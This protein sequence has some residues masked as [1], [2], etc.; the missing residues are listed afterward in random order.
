MARFIF[1]CP[2]MLASFVVLVALGF[3]GPITQAQEVSEA[4]SPVT[5]KPSLQVQIG[6]ATPRTGEQMAAAAARETRLGPMTRRVKRFRPTIGEQEYRQLKA[7]AAESY[8][9]GEERAT[10][11]AMLTPQATPVLKGV[12]FAG[13]DRNGAAADIGGGPVTSEVADMHGAAGRSFLVSGENHSH[14]V[15]VSNSHVN[16]YDVNTD[17]GARTQVK[18]LSLNSFFGYLKP[19][20]DNPQFCFSPRVIYDRVWDRWIISAAADPESPTMMRFFFAVSRTSDPTGPFFVYNLNVTF[21]VADR[22]WDFPQ[23]GMD[24]DAIIFTAN[25]FVD[26]T[27]E[28]IDGRMITL[29]KALFYNG[30]S[31]TVPLFSGLVASVAPPL[32]LDRNRNT[33]LVAALPEDNRVTLYNLNHSSRSAPTLTVSA[34]GVPLYTVPPPA[35]QPGTTNKLDTLDSRFLSYSTQAGSRLFQVHT[36]SALVNNVAV[37]TPKFYEF[38]TATRTIVQQGLFFKSATSHDFNATIAANP[39]RD[40]WVTWSATDPPS[41][42]QAQVRFSGRRS[43]DPTGVIPAGSSLAGSAAFYNPSAATVERWGD[44][45]AVALDPSNSLRAW[46]VNERIISNTIWG[47][48]IGRIGF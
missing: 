23:V 41:G 44:Y 40:V 14:F 45:S 47:S 8:A 28:F 9:S 42:V 37:P 48:R 30:R 10:L 4:A 43:T 25:W 16:I 13:V 46:M 20:F 24:Q 27:G 36:V 18:S 35:A 31:G 17:T 29:A 21:G 33:F 34:I 12:N 32:V 22:F 7:L 6:E 19:A 39:S 15:Q 3:F 11:G 26:S 1:K 2:S 5:V 38:N